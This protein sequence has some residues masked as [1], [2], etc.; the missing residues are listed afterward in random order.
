MVVVDVRL[1]L[2]LAGCGKSPPAAFPHHS[3][4][5]RTAR[6][7]FASSLAA[8]L[9]DGLFAHLAVSS[10]TDKLPGLFAAYCTKIE[11]FRSLLE[12]I[13][14]AEAKVPNRRVT[15]S[16]SA[17]RSLCPETSRPS[18]GYLSSSHFLQFNRVPKKDCRPSSV[19]THSRLTMGG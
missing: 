8:A 11:F 9:L 3:E 16:S 18:T 10:D 17:A 12:T 5:H 6:V 15:S 19:K 2:V 13:A 4:A 7:R 14:V 1:D